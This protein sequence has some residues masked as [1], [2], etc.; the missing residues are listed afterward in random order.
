MTEKQYDVVALIEAVLFLSQEPIPRKKLQDICS[1]GTGEIENALQTLRHE[2]QKTSRGLTLLETAEGF[3]LGTK[4]ELAPMLNK[5]LEEEHSLAPLSRAALETVAIIA[6][7]QPITRVEIENIRGVKADG[8]IEN[9]LKR[10]LVQIAGRKEVPGKPF[11]YSTTAE[12]L[13]Y[14]GL[15]GLGE[16]EYL[17]KEL[18]NLSPQNNDGDKQ[19]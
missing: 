19:P 15:S 16:I 7:K 6:V 8:V 9:L 1:V 5:L 13:Q 14:F 11:I 4:P 18:N 2:L 17:E 12:F 10:G 3:R